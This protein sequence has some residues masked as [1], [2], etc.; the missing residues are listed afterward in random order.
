[1]RLLLAALAVAVTAAAAFAHQLTVFAF[2]ENGEVVVETRFSNGN[3]PQ[4]GEVRVL[5]AENTPLLTLPLAG[6]GTA[7]FPLD[8]AHA[9]TGLMIEVS[10]GSGHEN[11]WILTPEDIARGSED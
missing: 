7:R 5:D 9:A 4:L 11:Y 2:V 10:T 3:A 8:P 6:D 1:M